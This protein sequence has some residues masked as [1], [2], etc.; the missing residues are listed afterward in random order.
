MSRA[1]SDARLNFRLAGELKKTIE[2]AAA[3]MGQTVSDF[4]ISTLVQTARKVLQDQQVTRVSERDRRLVMEMLDDQSTQPNQA[5]VQSRQ[6]VSEAGRLM[7]TWIIR[8]LERK[9]DRS[10]FDCGES[11]LNDWLKNRASQFDRRN[12]SRTFVATRPGDS[13]V[14][15]YYAI[16]SHRVLHEVLPPT[17]I[18][19]TSAAGRSRC[20]AWPTCRRPVCPKAG[21]R[22]TA[23]G[24][25]LAACGGHLRASRHSGGRGRGD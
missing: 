13:R 25:C 21:A 3:Q 20:L 2:E 15:G 6:T 4:A 14:L 9:H 24:G 11:V 1:K 22:I 16:S 18:Q 7:A 8:R 5:L 12:L 17:G 19:G 23:S 10:S